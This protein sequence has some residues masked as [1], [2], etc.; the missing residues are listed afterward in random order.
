MARRPSIISKAA[1]VFWLGSVAQLLFKL[2]I[3]V[4]HKLLDGD[5]AFIHSPIV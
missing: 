3:Y 2:A 4:H 5:Q 1:V